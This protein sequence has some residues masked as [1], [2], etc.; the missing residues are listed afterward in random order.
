ML[1]VF[2]PRIFDWKIFQAPLRAA[3]V[4]TLAVSSEERVLEIDAELRFIDT[5]QNSSIVPSEPSLL[6]LTFGDAFKYNT[7]YPTKSI[8]ADTFSSTWDSDGNIMTISDDSTDWQGTWAGTTHNTMVSKLSDYSTG[9]VGTQVNPMT[10]FGAST[11]LGTDGATW[12]SNGLISVNGVLYDFI[13]RQIYGDTGTGWRQSAFGCQLIKSADHGVTFTPLPPATGQPFTSPMFPGAKFGAPIFIQYGKDY[14][15]NTV[16]NSDLYVYAISTNGF[17]NNGDSLTL[18]RCLISNIGNL[19]AADWTFYLGGDGMDNANWGSLASAVPIVSKSR[20][21][22]IAGAQYLPAFKC[23]VMLEWYYPSVEQG[24]TIDRS[25]TVWDI[26]K[27]ATPWGPWTL[28]Q[29]TTWDDAEGLGLYNPNIVP[30]SVA[31]DGGLTFTILTSGDFDNTD[32]VNG[33]YTLTVIPVTA[34]W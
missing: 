16:H 4:R 10:A 19:N 12:K 13:S 9:L 34:V 8:A 28:I 6:A 33:D 30:S 15:G 5:D 24:L 21:L 3:N 29:S 20:S 2:D 14:Q 17:W 27:S 23:Y 26:Y 1:G 25:E 7:N 22:G 11:Q 32:V 18:G 31:P